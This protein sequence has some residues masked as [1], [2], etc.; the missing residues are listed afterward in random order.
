MLQFLLTPK[1]KK[2]FL[3]PSLPVM[4]SFVHVCLEREEEEERALPGGH[5]QVAY[6]FSSLVGLFPFPW[7]VVAIVMPF[8]A[9]FLEP[10]DL[11]ARHFLPTEISCKG[12]T[13]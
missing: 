7:T 11:S 6:I 3:V 13:F 4:T 2:S 8:V 9:F 1:D 5:D 12:M 10:C